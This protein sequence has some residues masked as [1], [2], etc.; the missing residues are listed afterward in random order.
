MTPH[1]HLLI[2]TGEISGDLQGS[3][4]IEAL[5]QAAVARDWTL[6]ITAL[7][8]QRMA[9]AGATLLETTSHIG[10]I[11]LLESL[12]YI[13]STLAIQ[14]KLR[15]YLEA[16]PPDLTIL[17]DYPGANVPLAGYLKQTYP[18]CPIVYY[19]APQEWAWAFSQGI[20]RKI[21]ERTDQ[22]LAIFAQEAEYYAARGATVTWVGHPFIDTLAGGLSWADARDRLKIPLQQK[23]IALLP[24]S[25]Q[26]ELEQIWPT[27]ATA[28]QQI[29][30][31][32]PTAHFWI[33]VAQAAFRPFLSAL[34]AQT[35][36]NASLLD[37][38]QLALRAADLIIGKSGTV[39]LEAALLDVPQIVV[40]R[41]HPV[42]GWLYRKL[43][44]FKVPFISPVNLIAKRAIVP[45]LLQEM[46]TPAAIAQNAVALLASQTRRDQMR[47]DYR[48]LKLGEPG[49]LSRAANLILDSLSPQLKQ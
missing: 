43:L 22:I 26:Q 25:R 39:N 10:A 21:V 13:R 36:I 42:S 31:Q 3:L 32:I 14:R 8:G 4:L 30:Q 15:S 40:Y 41:V 5:H 7:G 47:S 48:A 18:N 1:F 24:A 11:G 23:A 17:I 19:I 9:A 28:A 6:H 12:P 38:A 45:E 16:A 20:T 27:L 46:A 37:D 49:V 35:G 33:P 34:I 44:K 29:Q 2:S